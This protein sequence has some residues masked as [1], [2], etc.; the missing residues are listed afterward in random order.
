MGSATLRKRACANAKCDRSAFR[1]PAIVVGVGFVATRL[2]P[3]GWARRRETM[4][5]TCR[6]VNTFGWVVTHS[7]GVLLLDEA[8]MW[9]SSLVRVF[10]MSV[11]LASTSI[12]LERQLFV[13]AAQF[14]VFLKMDLAKFRGSA[15]RVV[16]RQS[17]RRS[18]GKCRMCR[19]WFGGLQRI[20]R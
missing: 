4:I 10:W 12:R 15:T 7:S 8:T 19:E 5:M 3:E 17:P 2:Y 11:I 1:H 16:A 9:K 18:G 20:R 14:L 6:L 13:S